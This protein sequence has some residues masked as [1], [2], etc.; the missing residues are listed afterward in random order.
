M[1]RFFISF[2]YFFFLM[3]RRPP[4]STRTDTLFP[5]TTLFRS[6]PGADAETLENTTTQVIEQQ[7]KGIDHLRYMS[8]TSDSL[9]RAVITLTFEQGTDADTAQVQVQNK[10]QLATARRPREVQQSGLIVATATNSILLAAAIYSEDG[11][12]S[13]S[14]MADYVASRVQDPVSRVPGVGDIRVLGG[15]YAMRIW[16]D[17]FK[18]QNYRLT[19]ADVKSAIQAQNAQVSAGQLGSQPAAEGQPLTAT[20]TAQSRLQNVDQFKA[21]ILRTNPDG[22]TVKIGDVARV[23]IGNED[24][25]FNLELN[26]KPASG[27]ILKLAPGAN[28]VQ[29]VDLVKARIAE[30]QKQ[31][32]P[33]IRVVY[34]LDSTPFVRLSI[35]QVVH[36][37]IEATVLV[38]LVMF[39]FLQNWRATLVPTIAIPVVLLGTFGVLAIPGFSF[40]PLPLLR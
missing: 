1:S 33:D 28:A 11:S 8:S 9:G 17:P 23:E 20:V 14:D 25:N 36:T 32:P 15:Q 16:V 34:P 38:F 18:L 10:L 19:F 39:L 26:G 31:F 29:T 24:Y 21:V 6:Y 30:L 13:V 22:S 27:L 12:H 2:V 35:E 4:R 3:I 7:M 37:I 5:Y 40:N